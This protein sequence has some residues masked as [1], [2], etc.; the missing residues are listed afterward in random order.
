[1]RTFLRSEPEHQQ[2]ASPDSYTPTTE[3]AKGDKAATHARPELKTYL[4]K[5]VINGY[6]T[7]FVA[8]LIG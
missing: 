6:D 8:F 7:I 1:M 5:E 2:R 3:A 4:S